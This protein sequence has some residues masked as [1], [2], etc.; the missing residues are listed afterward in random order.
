MH[1]RH[2]IWGRRIWGLVGLGMMVGA[3]GGEPTD[4]A[5]PIA[6]SPTPNPSSSVFASPTGVGSATVPPIQPLAV[7]LIPPTGA[8]ERLPQVSVGRGDPF[9]AVSNAP[10]VSIAPAT[11]TA[12]PTVE[13]VAAA[14]TPLLPQPLS[15]VP[16]TPLPVLVPA[17]PALP[18]VPVAT[19]AAPVQP[20][21]QVSGVVQIGSKLSAIVELPGETS[22]YV[23][24]GDRLG[25]GALVR[26]HRDGRTTQGNF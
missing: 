15:T 13:P 22:R 24:V 10:T 11:P 9:S 19:P 18:Q 12:E 16:T 3:C 2:W 7:P 26:R 14:P 6:P 17:Q 5:S 4:T 23:S 21:I 20:D 1:Q 25:N 8:A